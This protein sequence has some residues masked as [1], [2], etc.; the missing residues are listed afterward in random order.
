MATT[1]AAERISYEDLYERWERS[2]W[3]ASEIDFRRDSEDWE[4]RFSDVDRR[5][6][7]FNWSL[8]FWGEDAVA[9][10]VATSLEAIRPQLTWGFHK[11]FGRLD[12]MADELRRDRSKP[13]LAAAVA[14]Y[15]VVIEATM[16]QPG[17]H[18]FERHVERT[19]LLPGFR[20]GIRHV[21]EDEQ[22]HIGFGVKLLSE[23]V[24]EDPECRDSVAELLREVAPWTTAVLIPPNWDMRYVEALG[25][26]LE[27][28]AEAGV[29]SFESKMR[30]AGLPLE[31]LPGPPIIPLGLEPRE[32]AARGIALVR[33][34][35]MGEGNGAVSAT[36]EHQELLFDTLRRSVNPDHGL[37]RP[38]TLQWD[39]GD[40][41]PW[42]IRIDDGT[43]RASAGRVPDPDLTLRCRYSDFVDIVGGRL[44]ERRA[45]LTGKLRPRGSL[46]LLAR[47]PQ[48]IG[49]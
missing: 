37:K 4:R 3:R 41:E 26:T 16:A 17:Q 30:A 21:S 10:N 27:E 20:E 28:V 23:L 38:T 22:R 34:G 43:T 36:S 7:I 15:H 31:E 39:F 11:V 8:F 33:A 47:M 18:V 13:Q 46:R 25:F 24:A 48:I 49:R 45:V 1:T 5:A 6:A 42:F 35:I 32:Q 19:G 2:N 40:A 44:D 14:L 9:D 12:R 29:R